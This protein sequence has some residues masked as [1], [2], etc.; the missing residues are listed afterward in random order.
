MHLDCR[1][2]VENR[3]VSAIF[4]ENDDMND[5]RWIYNR[6]ENIHI[7]SMCMCTLCY[8]LRR[9]F[10]IAINNI[11]PVCKVV[12]KRKLKSNINNNCRLWNETS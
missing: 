11:G 1:I 10:T 2:Y 12:E 6:T 5:K 8:S 4:R 3:S 7:L 9:N